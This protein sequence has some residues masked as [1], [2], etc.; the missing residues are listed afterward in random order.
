LENAGIAELVL[1]LNALMAQEGIVDGLS[2]RATIM[3]L[4]K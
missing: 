3:R 1:R 4:V 2:L